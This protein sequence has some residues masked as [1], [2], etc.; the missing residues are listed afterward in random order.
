MQDTLS[1][2]SV[3]LSG[4]GAALGLFFAMALLARRPRSAAD[5]F[6]AAFCAAFAVL[7]AGDV[8]VVA[9]APKSWVA[10]GN[11][12]DGVFLLL[13]PLFYFYVASSVRGEGPAIGAL[14]ASLL[15]ALLS[16]LW[17]SWRVVF[18]AG[19]PASDGEVGDFMPAAYTFSFVGVAVAQL[20]G[21]CAA[22]YWTVRT[23]AR[24]V[25]QR[26]SSVHEFD[27]R[28]IQSMIAWA[29]AAAL[30]WVAGIFIRHPAWSLFSIAMPPL[31]FLALGIRAQR[32]PPVPPATIS[33]ASPA[34]PEPSAKYAKS[35]LT[36]ER[37][38]SLAAQL[39]QFMARDKAFLE[40]ELTLGQ[41]AERTGIPQ[42]QLS[43][44]LNQHLGCSFFEYVNRLRVEEAKRCLGDPAYR[45][46]TV[47]ELGLASGFNSKAAFNAAFKRATGLTPSEFR[48]QGGRDQRTAS[49]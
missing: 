33:A 14:A 10:L 35:G 19:D 49:P 25:E 47:L 18:G 16:L 17:F 9:L 24:A 3:A 31:M 34:E 40:G 2:W 20:L 46:Q 1:A 44:V 27:L 38:K 45:D 36:D 13:P 26:F 29:G 30:V 6:L 23:H 28:W 42:H 7:M 8:M 11:A 32:Q 15:P 41:L 5:A 21:Y 39:E 37:M 43:Q 48:A 22:A 4:F 12:F